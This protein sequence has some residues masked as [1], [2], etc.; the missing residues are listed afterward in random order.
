MKLSMEDEPY[1][2]EYKEFTEQCSAGNVS[3]EQVGS[4]IVRMAQ[5]FAQKNME[6]SLAESSANGEAVLIVQSNDDS[7]GKPMSVSKAEILLKGTAAYEASNM[8]KTHIQNIEQYINAL[9]YLQKGILNEYS[10]M[11]NS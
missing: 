3:A 9:K 2:K 10:H 8:V 6:L 5:Y 1:Y 7:T 4:V 11:G